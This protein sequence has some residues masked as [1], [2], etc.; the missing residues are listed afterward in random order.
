MRNA[1]RYSRN[2]RTKVCISATEQ[3]PSQLEQ[4]VNEQSNQSKGTNPYVIGLNLVNVLLIVVVSC[5][6]ILNNR[7]VIIANKR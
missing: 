1:G 7:R 6:F 4:A 5:I 3:T 2:Q